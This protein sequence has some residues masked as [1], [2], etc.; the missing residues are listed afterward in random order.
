MGKHDQAGIL[1]LVLGDQLTA[2]LSSLID[3]NP[4]TDTI[5]MAEVMD[6]CTYVP[7]HPKKIVFILSAMRHFACD[8]RE[9]GFQVAYF[10]LGDADQM[11]SLRDA[12][13]AVLEKTGLQ[14]LVV[15]EP[16]EWRLLAEF[17]TW[18][19]ELD[20]QV[21]VRPDTRFIVDH[22]WFETWANGR[23]L[24][25]MEDFYR[26]IRRRTGL[27]MHANQPVGG[28]WNFDK[29]NRKPF[30]KGVD[31]PMPF[32]VYPDAITETVL[33]LVEDRFGDNFGDLRPFSYAVA[34]EDAEQ[35][36]GYFIDHVLPQFGD[37]Q[38]AMVAG[39]T[40]L[41]HS[42]LSMYI[43]IGLLDPMQVCRLVEEAYQ[44]GDAPINAVEGFIRQI[45]GWREYVRGI[46]WLKMPDYAETNTFAAD[47]ALPDIYWGAETD[48]VCMRE[49]VSQTR[50]HAYAHHIQRLMVTGN[51]ALLAGINPQ[52][53]QAWYLAVYI[54]A[55]EWVELPNTHGMALFADDGVM[56]T[57]PYA[58]GG[59]YIQK[60]SDYCSSCRFEPT[61]PVGENACP[62]SYLYWDFLI[63]NRPKLSTNHRLRTVYS[64]LDRMAPERVTQM[65]QNAEVFLN[66]L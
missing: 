59:R 37:Y 45:I 30:K 50:E 6:E 54:D 40:T 42:I 25:R 20:V 51:F 15:T 11:S 32:A 33:Q 23:K 43:N 19:E 17:E 24:L 57:K 3:A 60:M 34:K 28:Q 65:R 58:A 66:E 12:V 52:H 7:H 5:I 29:E 64:T 39:E 61:D 44:R 35:A 4:D 22:T 46:Y 48:M 47:R 36:L 41:F 9:R 49:C 14:R 63:R 2:S 27:L 62:F 8:L 18:R 53:V 31:I 16:G 1:R 21:D 55:F 26:D 13:E 10:E 56:A 38:D